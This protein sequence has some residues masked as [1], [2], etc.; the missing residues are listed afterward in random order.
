MYS[1]FIASEIGPSGTSAALTMISR[2]PDST[3]ASIGELGRLRLERHVEGDEHH[4][5]AAR[6]ARDVRAR[7]AASRAEHGYSGRSFQLFVLRLMWS[8]A[9]APEL[10]DGEQRPRHHEHE[11]EERELDPGD[12]GQR[13][14]D[15]RQHDRRAEHEVAVAADTANENAS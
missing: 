7:A 15:Q 4:R 8:A 14:Q 5:A 6:D 12:D 3:A 11:Q 2:W 9:A 13:D 1:Y 10:W